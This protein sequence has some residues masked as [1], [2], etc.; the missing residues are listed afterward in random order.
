MDREDI[1]DGIVNIL[2][3]SDMCV[4]T[5]NNI[6]EA[7]LDDKKFKIIVEEIE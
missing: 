5:E 2:N 4:E 7:S 3:M 1:I 6:I